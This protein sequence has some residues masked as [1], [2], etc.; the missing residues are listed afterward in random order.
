MNIKLL[1]YFLVLFLLSQ[2]H[3]FEISR[4]SNPEIIR[5]MASLMV[6]LPSSRYPRELFLNYALYGR[7]DDPF[8]YDELYKYFG[9]SSNFTSEGSLIIG[10]DLKLGGIVL[11]G[12]TIAIP[13]PG[14]VV[15]V[16]SYDLLP[17]FFPFGYRI[18]NC[19]GKF[20]LW[21][22]GGLENATFNGEVVCTNCQNEYGFSEEDFFFT[23]NNRFWVKYGSMMNN[24]LGVFSFGYL[25]NYNEKNGKGIIKVYLYLYYYKGYKIYSFVNDSF[26]NQMNIT[27]CRNLT[28]LY[29]ESLWIK[30]DTLEGYYNSTGTMI[31]PR[32]LRRIE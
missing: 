17:T 22:T 16:I 32:T 10:N 18:K 1:F 21:V 25:S 24:T 19:T 7:T 12:N 20:Y 29:N 15:T 28:V 9:V 30:V 2:P 4:S 14:S 8:S 31:F 3:S 6:G 5:A 26:L 13:I 11:E 23:E 27:D